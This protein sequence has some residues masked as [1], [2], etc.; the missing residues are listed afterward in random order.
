MSKNVAFWFAA[1]GSTAK[2]HASTNDCAVTGSPLWK[3]K[4]SRIVIVQLC[5]SSDSIDSA[6]TLT[7]SDVSGSYSTSP[8]KSWSRTFEPQT[9]VEFWGISDCGSQL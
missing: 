2:F 9:S 5:W 1:S 4:S 7:A 6:T 8:A 3:V